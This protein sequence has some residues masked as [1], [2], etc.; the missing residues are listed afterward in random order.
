MAAR[1]WSKYLRSAKSVEQLKQRHREA[2]RKFHPDVAGDNADP[3]KTDTINKLYKQLY[4]K[5]HSTEPKVM[6]QAQ[7]RVPDEKTSDPAIR[8]Q[9]RKA[10]AAA[11]QLLSALTGWGVEV[12]VKRLEADD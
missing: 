4:E 12:V 7:E 11:F 3:G 6:K 5:R 10:M 8:K 1:D 9:Q 2:M